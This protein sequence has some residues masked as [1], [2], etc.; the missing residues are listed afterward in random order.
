MNKK[1]SLI[2]LALTFSL[3]SMASDFKFNYKNLN[4]LAS[5][6]CAKNQPIKIQD[7]EVLTN[8]IQVEQINTGINPSDKTYEIT[9]TCNAI[10]NTNS[11]SFN[12]FGEELDIAIDLSSL[13]NISGTIGLNSIKIKLTHNKI[14]SIV[15]TDSLLGDKKVL[16][17]KSMNWAPNNSLISL[18]KKNRISL[19]SNRKIAAVERNSILEIKAPTSLNTFKIWSTDSFACSKFDIKRCQDIIK[20]L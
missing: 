16:L 1:Y 10:Y 14:N 15:F 8:S 19:K 3:S 9:G 13:N 5:L 18:N 11:N 4:T 17:L 7:N 2:F 12:S 6:I 20:K